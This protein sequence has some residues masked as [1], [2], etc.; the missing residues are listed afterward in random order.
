MLGEVV[1]AREQTLLPEILEVL[2]AVAA[3]VLDY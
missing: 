2:V 3:G 1:V